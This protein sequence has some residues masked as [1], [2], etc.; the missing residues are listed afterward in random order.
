M[1]GRVFL[2]VLLCSSMALAD[3]DFSSRGLH[4]EAGETYLNPG[5]TL[6]LSRRGTT[7]TSGLGVELS[8]HHFVDKSSGVGL[9]GQAQVLGQQQYRLCGGLQAT[10]LMG[11]LP[12][13]I[14]LGIASE[15]PDAEGILRTSLHVAPFISLGLVSAGFRMS[16]PL[17]TRVSDISSVGDMPGQGFE[18]GLVLALKLPLNLQRW[19]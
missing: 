9:F 14:E 11:S 13:G 18:A 2:G 1:N 8:L 17:V 4:P 3:P 15:T 16:I 7:D 10:H 19:F 6:S 5:V 12:L